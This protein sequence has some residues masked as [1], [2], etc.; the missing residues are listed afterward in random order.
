[1]T[2]THLR[3]LV[4][5]AVLALALAACGD[6]DQATAPDDD[7]S[8]GDA[9]TDLDADPDAD[10][11]A[12]TDE[13]GTDP[14]DDAETGETSPEAEP[15]VRAVDATLAEGSAAFD[16]TVDIDTE[17]LTDT[18]TS[19]GVIDFDGDR[20]QFELDTNA[21]TVTALVTTE[22]ILL[23]IG[24]ESGWVRADPRELRGTPLEAFGL[25]TLTMQDPSVN[26]QLLRGATDDVEELGSEDIDGESTTHYRVVVDVQQAAA[27]AEG[28]S[29]QQVAEVTEQ[30]GQSTLEMEVWIDDSDRIRRTAQTIDLAD[31]DMVQTDGELQGTIDVTI[32]LR[33]F[34]QDVTVTEPDS[35]EVIDIDEETL[36][37]L[38]ES[39]G[40]QQ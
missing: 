13:E 32:D 38:I 34:G 15:V 35:G 33:D 19:S 21:G 22:G 31:A 8:P 3:P 36:E 40:A 18:A 6:S 2:F 25:A 24:D 11:D 1:M 4:V 39:M 20:R 28:V 17:E 30:T 5:I 27:Q 29:Q 37:Q 16:V 12:E 9:T 14:F 26:L 7:V 10:P 23:A